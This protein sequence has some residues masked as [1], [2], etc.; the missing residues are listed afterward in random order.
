MGP[1]EVDPDERNVGQAVYE[2]IPQRTSSGVGNCVSSQ[3][4]FQKCIIIY[5]E[6]TCCTTRTQKNSVEHT[7]E[8]S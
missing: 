3:R 6:E 8:L 4:K 1:S 5:S 2:V 7:W